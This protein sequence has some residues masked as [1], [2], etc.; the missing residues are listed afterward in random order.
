MPWEES[1]ATRSAATTSRAAQHITQE[2]SQKRVVRGT[3][4]K[5]WGMLARIL[6]VAWLCCVQVGGDVSDVAQPSAQPSFG[7]TGLHE[8][9]NDSLAGLRGHVGAF[10]DFDSDMYVDVVW[11]EEDRKAIRVMLWDRNS[12]SFTAVG[13]AVIQLPQPEAGSVVTTAAV[14]LN[15]D[16]RLDL[17]VWCQMPS[18]QGG[19]GETSLLAYFGNT[20]RFSAPLR[21]PG[22][23]VGQVTVVEVS[24][25]LSAHASTPK[26]WWQ[27]RRT[28]KP[29]LPCNPYRW[30]EDQLKGALNPVSP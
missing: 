2:G 13:A 4:G 17:L 26:T 8:L 15:Q 5:G 16:G 11:I 3:G 9:P 1:S 22:G 24:L 6:L 30:L 25:A 7:A 14:D 21:L 20:H 12:L 27:D 28:S 23:A 19:R 29:S 18:Q 10:G